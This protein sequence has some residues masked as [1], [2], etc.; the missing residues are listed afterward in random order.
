MP[1][2]SAYRISIVGTEAGRVQTRLSGLLLVTCTGKPEFSWRLWKQRI[3][4]T[5]SRRKSTDTKPLL[6]IL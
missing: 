5:R 2:S 1:L 3:N 4:G 6:L